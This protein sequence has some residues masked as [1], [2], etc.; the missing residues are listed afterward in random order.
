MRPFWRHKAEDEHN[1][2]MSYTDL[3]AGFLIV[4]IIVSLI[5][6]SRIV[7]KDRI[8]H[9]GTVPLD[10]LKYD[11]M[12][13]GYMAVHPFL[14]DSLT[15]EINR[16]K[17]ISLVNVVTQFEEIVPETSKIE[18]EIDTKRGSIVLRGKNN[19]VLFLDH[20]TSQQQ[21][22]DPMPILREYLQQYGRALVQKTMAI[23]NETGRSVELRI[24]GH[25]DPQHT[26]GRAGNES[27]L[28]NLDL[29]SKR[30]EKVYETIFN[31]L[32]KEEQE[33]AKRNMISVGYSFATRLEDMDSLADKSLDVR[34][35][36]IEFRIIVK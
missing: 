36:R 26:T 27:F 6:T 30:A 34:S 11:T 18:R 12:P 4:F 10:T 22:E 24:E 33:F 9:A 15:G 32:S 23:S 29:S 8:L 35:R 13:K 16:L 1:F 25:T 20:N 3:M 5:L 31:T 14:L 17:G 2:W 7:P 28:W 21:M 19:Q